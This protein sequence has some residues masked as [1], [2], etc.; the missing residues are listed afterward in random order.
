VA[1]DSD[2]AWLKGDGAVAIWRE[3]REARL[4]QLVRETVQRMLAGSYGI[5]PA[6][7][8]AHEGFG[9]RLCEL[10]LGRS[11]LAVHAPRWSEPSGKSRKEVEGLWDAAREIALLEGV[12]LG[13]L[14]AKN[15]EVFTREDVLASY[16]FAC[17]LMEV[18]AGR[19]ARLLDEIGRSGLSVQECLEGELRT[20][21]PTLERRFER[22]LAEMGS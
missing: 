17:F 13:A 10:A 4:E 11:D 20:E 21:L 9:L 3:G 12:D 22:W 19:L 7:A 8:W 18:H 1:Q 14:L 6:Q 16:A 5:G 2:G 15:H